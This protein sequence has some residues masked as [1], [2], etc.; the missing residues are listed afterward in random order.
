MIQSESPELETSP[1]VET[2][3]G[4]EIPSNGNLPSKEGVRS[5]LNELTEFSPVV[6]AIDP[7][8]SNGKPETETSGGGMKAA[9][10]RIALRSKGMRPSSGTSVVELVRE[11]RKGPLYGYDPEP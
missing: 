4:A 9:L 8:E 7:C 3:I 5:S 2:V 1:V 6:V 10:E 11:G